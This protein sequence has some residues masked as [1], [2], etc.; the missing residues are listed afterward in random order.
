MYWFGIQKVYVSQICDTDWFDI[1]NILI[2]IYTS[3][4]NIYII[5]KTWIFLGLRI[6]MYYHKKEKDEWFTKVE[7]QNG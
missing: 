5:C 6:V 4:D 7:Y 1:Q 2:D 3:S